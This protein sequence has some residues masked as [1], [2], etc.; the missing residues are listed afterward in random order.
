M[1]LGMRKYH[2]HKEEPKEGNN[3]KERNKETLCRDHRDPISLT[4]EGETCGITER[5]QEDRLRG[6][7]DHAT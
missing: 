6:E 7:G 3:V 1:F 2:I 5:P 4:G